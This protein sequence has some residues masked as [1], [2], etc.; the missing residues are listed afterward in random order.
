M[1][2]NQIDATEPEPE[3]TEIQ[4]QKQ[5]RT[6]HKGLLIVAG[7]VSAIAI[8]GGGFTWWYKTNLKPVTSEETRS[9]LVQIKE[10]E[11][12][13]AIAQ[14]L[15]SKKLIRNAL[16][17]RLYMRQTGVS[18]RVQA[19]VYRFNSS[20]K[21]SDIARQLASG[22]TAVIS[23]T[24]RGGM[25]LTQVQDLLVT[26][27]FSKTDVEAAL[28][29]QY[30]NP[31][32]KDKPAESNLEGYL[33]PDTYF[34][35]E[36]RPLSLLIELML[37][38]TNKKITPEIREQWASRGLNLHQGLTLAS[39]VEK[40][41]ATPEDR[42]QVA[43]VFYKRLS[44][45]RNLESDVTFQY[46]AALLNVEPTTEVESPYN[47]Y[48]NSGLPPGPICMPELSAIVAV[49]N[50]ASTDWLFFIADKEGNVRYALDEEKHKENIEKYLQ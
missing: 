30:A 24:V 50:P 34:I 8:V 23:V 33:F 35:D 25:R 20:Q 26:K 15:E 41:A 27:G 36:G 17:F 16:A 12:S 43:Q 19:G 42:R 6:K 45:P 39:I 29:A 5:E 14:A 46:G 3:S 40:E 44:M 21:P 22:D 2:K 18:S 10:G 11:S 7:V 37:E 13:A 9:Q 31:V 48:L 47:T 49:A 1:S 32:L 4:F 28:N 38:N